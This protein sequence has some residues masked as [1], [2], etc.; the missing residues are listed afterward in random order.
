MNIQNGNTQQ[1]REKTTTEKK[2]NNQQK[3]R[4]LI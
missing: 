2:R 3:T 1:L 4:G